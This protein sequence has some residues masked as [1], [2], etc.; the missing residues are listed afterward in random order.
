MKTRKL[1][2]Y[3]INKT[4]GSGR[5]IAFTTTLT[6]YS[7]HQA[8]GKA[9]EHR[10]KDDEREEENIAALLKHSFESTKK[11][12][13]SFGKMILIGDTLHNITDGIAIGAAFT[14]DI[15]GGL[16]TTIAVFCHE[17]PHELG[18]V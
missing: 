3:H 7:F 13:K 8:K 14:Q 16:S 17:L 2:K 12:I 10:S 5:I 1:S 4:F 18:I 6:I 15:A 9:E 11:S